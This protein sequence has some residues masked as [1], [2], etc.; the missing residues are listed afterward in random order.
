MPGIILRY[1]VVSVVKANHHVVIL[2]TGVSVLLFFE[3]ANILQLFAHMGI[4]LA[5]AR[6]LERVI[7]S[8]GANRISDLIDYRLVILGSMLPDIID[9]PLGG[10]IL[11]ETLG[12]GRI[13]CHTLLFLLVFSG[14]GLFLWYAYRKSWLLVLAVG[15]FFHHVL[16][17]MWLLPQTF[18]WP[19]YG[20]G[21]AK[22][23]P[24]GWFWQWIETLL[25]K[26]HVFIPELI[27]VVILT[28]FVFELV[29]HKK[30]REFINTGRLIK[31]LPNEAEQKK[32][33]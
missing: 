8:Q 4:T 3:G 30:L 33:G 14:L 31:I 19:M 20:W 10:I 25:T 27:G 24:D 15:I 22:G 6:G 5:S 9:K 1:I 13:Y 32:S 29:H 7:I 2:N 26:P 23:D 11:K 16:D 12:N 21:F 17:F 18:L 28:L